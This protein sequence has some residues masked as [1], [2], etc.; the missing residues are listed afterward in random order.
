MANKATIHES[1]SAQQGNVELTHI[2]IKKRTKILF[3]SHDKLLNALTEYEIARSAYNEAV[4]E[5]N[6]S[7]ERLAGVSYMLLK[8]KETSND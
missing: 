8:S 3:K 2:E 7:V 6:C 4:D 5:F 1:D